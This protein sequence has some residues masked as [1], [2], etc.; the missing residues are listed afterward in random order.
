M[1]KIVVLMLLA[2]LA[3]SSCAKRTG[4]EEDR[5]Q[6]GDKAPGFSLGNI[7]GTEQVVS[8]KVFHNSDATVVIIWS[9]ACPSCRQVLREMDRLR[10]EYSNRMVSFV[11]INFD[12]ENVQGVRA[13][14]R[15]EDIDLVT[16]WDR[17]A[18]T[19]REYEAYDYTFSLFIVNREGRLAM[20]QYDH[21]PDLAEM[22]AR[23]IDRLAPPTRR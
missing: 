7:F 12:L 20:V 16:L 11:S 14:L 18:R 3:V 15:G 13:F 19:V 23:E 10:E 22:V 21:P 4:I 6:E 17:G 1:K 2:V 5:L 9:M 8:G